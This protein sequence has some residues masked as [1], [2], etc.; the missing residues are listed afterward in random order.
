MKQEKKK[1]LLEMLE[2]DKLSKIQK[3]IE[4]STDEHALNALYNRMSQLLS[5][6]V[7]ARRPAAIGELTSTNLRSLMNACLAREK[8]LK[9]EQRRRVIQQKQHYLEYGE[10]PNGK[11]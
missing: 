7:C 4:Q 3:E 5:D 11:K 6:A 2:R 9:G 8:I 1:T 10:Y